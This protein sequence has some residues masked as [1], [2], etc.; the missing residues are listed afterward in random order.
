M[1][2]IE[3]GF[4]ALKNFNKLHYFTIIMPSDLIVYHELLV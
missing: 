3:L 1:I 2:I 4:N